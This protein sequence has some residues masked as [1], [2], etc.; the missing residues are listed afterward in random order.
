MKRQNIQR[1]YLFIYYITPTFW[2]FLN[3]LQEDVRMRC[4]I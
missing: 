4:F 2:F 3:H 1:M